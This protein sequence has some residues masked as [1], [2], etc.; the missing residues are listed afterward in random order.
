[1]PRVF[2]TFPPLFFYDPG[3]TFSLYLLLSF[4]GAVF[5]PQSW[6]YTLH[7]LTE[8]CVNVYVRVI[9]DRDHT[10]IRIKADGRVRV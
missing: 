4:F 7:T 8:R 6:P 5:L 1:M 2:L 10:I 3:S 9:T